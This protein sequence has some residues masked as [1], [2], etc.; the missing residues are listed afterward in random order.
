MDRPAIPDKVVD[1]RIFG[2][3]GDGSKVIHR[4]R[5]YDNYHDDGGDQLD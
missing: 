3:V 5:R 1:H 4:H 2:P